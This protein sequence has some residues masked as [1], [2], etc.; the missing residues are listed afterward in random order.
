M[1]TSL[2]ES[3]NDIPQK[4][5]N[6]QHLKQTSKYFLHNNVL[7]TRLLSPFDLILFSLDPD[8]QAE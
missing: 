5:L 7:T 4:F 2:H 8:F 3:A 1:E 6:L